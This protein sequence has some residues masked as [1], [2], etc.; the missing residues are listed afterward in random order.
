M[1]LKIQEL[2]DYICICILTFLLLV[3]NS[4]ENGLIIFNSNHF[5][6]KF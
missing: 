6:F 4:F 3:N 1:I 5:F 2:E